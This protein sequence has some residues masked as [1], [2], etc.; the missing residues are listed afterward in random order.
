MWIYQSLLLQNSKWTKLKLDSTGIKLLSLASAFNE[1]AEIFLQHF[2]NSMFYKVNENSNPEPQAQLNWRQGFARQVPD[3]LPVT[4]SSLT[5]EA[6]G[7]DPKSNAISQL[8]ANPVAQTGR[9]HLPEWQEW[10]YLFSK[11]LTN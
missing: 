11:Q 1:F 3:T 7:S 10:R 5:P 9:F 8:S 2:Q 6:M 4:L